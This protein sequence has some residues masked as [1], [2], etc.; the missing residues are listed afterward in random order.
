MPAEL[1]EYLKSRGQ[2]PTSG[3]YG[4]GV[5]QAISVTYS[6]SPVPSGDRAASGLLV[7][8]SDARKDGAPAGY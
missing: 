5:S 2:V 4:L 6:S 1:V 7:G 8:Q 3:P